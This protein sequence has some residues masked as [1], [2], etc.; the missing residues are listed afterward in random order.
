M[1]YGPEK[2][3]T[4]VKTPFLSVL[5][6]YR[7]RMCPVYS[8]RTCTSGMGWPSLSTTRPSAVMVP[9]ACAAGAASRTE[10]RTMAIAIAT[11]RFIEFP[12]HTGK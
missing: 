7:W 8:M 5:V 11:L 4:C 12:P 1:V 3:L 10:A 2:T 6:L 9:W